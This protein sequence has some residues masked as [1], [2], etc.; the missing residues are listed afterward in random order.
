MMDRLIAFMSRQKDWS[1]K[2]FGS[3][4][5]TKMTTD[6]IRKELIEIEDN[7]TDLV[8]WID[9]IILGLDGYWRAGGDPLE[10]MDRLEAKQRINLTRTYID[11]GE[12]RAVEHVREAP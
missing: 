6:H 5:R 4:I 3:A 8:E 10:L 2:N 11:H 1:S 12:N 9:V 7:P